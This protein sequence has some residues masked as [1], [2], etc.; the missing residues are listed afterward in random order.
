MR[1]ITHIV[2]HCSATKANIDANITLPG[3]DIGA[4]EID[5]WHRARGFNGIGYHYDIRRDGTIEIGR[6]L[7]IPGAHVSGHNSNTIGICLVGGLDACAHAENNFE[8]AQWQS[9]TKLVGDLLRRFPG[10]RV[11][12]HRDFPGVKKDC[13]CFDA[14]AWARGQGFAV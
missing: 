2:I 14:R 1:P 6:P 13:P 4:A 10:A 3:E 7:E 9:L 5:K 8:P 12:G 11:L